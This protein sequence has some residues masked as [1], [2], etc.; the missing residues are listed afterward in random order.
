MFSFPCLLIVEVLVLIDTIHSL[1]D[2]LPLGVD[3]IILDDCWYIA[4]D[5]LLL[6]G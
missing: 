4:C 3:G 1:A 2:F 5:D 6:I